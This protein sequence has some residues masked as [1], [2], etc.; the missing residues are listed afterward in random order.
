MISICIIS[1]YRK[2]QHSTTRWRS[3]SSRRCSRCS[4]NK[5]IIRRCNKCRCSNNKCIIRRCNKCRCSNNKCI[6]RRCSNNKCI[7]ACAADRH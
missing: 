5:C 1:S 2:K 6:I 4:N 3:S 7:I